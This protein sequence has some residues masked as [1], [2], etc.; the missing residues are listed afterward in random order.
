MRWRRLPSYTSIAERNFRTKR[1]PTVDERVRLYMAHWYLPP[2]I[3]T[4]KLSATIVRVNRI[5]NVTGVFGSTVV[6]K[7]VSDLDYLVSEP[8]T[9]R[10]LTITSITRPD[11]VFRFNND[12][13]FYCYQQKDWSIRFYCRDAQISMETSVLD[14][15]PLLLEFTDHSDTVVVER[16]GEA[17]VKVENPN[18]PVIKKLRKALPKAE[19]DEIINNTV[20]NSSPCQDLAAR[21]LQQ[22]Y[23][24]AI[25]WLLN[26]N[27]HF[28]YSLDI[29]RYDIPWD[30]KMDS[31]IFRGELTGLQYNPNAPDHEN[32][33]VLPR[34]RLVY[35]YSNSKLVDARITNT[36]D[37]IPDFLS[38]VNMTGP[39]LRRSDFLQH[40]GL[41]I[42]EGNDV[43]SG[44]KWSMVSN[45]VVL[46]PPPRFTSWAM[47]EL[48]EPW[49][50]FIP[51]RPDLSDVET[52]VQWM[53]SNQ[54][55]SKR[56][57]HR[58]KL[59][60]MDLYFHPDAMK[61]AKS[62]NEEIL[63]KY[64]LLFDEKVNGL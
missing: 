32:C 39:K 45:S 26:V 25:L 43:S 28:K 30:R 23:R 57:A 40:K 58:A 52:K 50:H 3:G 35:R 13:L 49:Q 9:A 44:L 55:E 4:P 33:E 31:A 60:I 17:M 47:E 27:R 2:C 34:C 10:N 41:I 5:K 61:D 7:T 29:P 8:G 16:D 22:T 63:R 21:P 6:S 54:E 38:G 48:L 64:R 37:K 1:F 18:I 11:E 12:D 36:F 15:F 53:L 20:N 14:G 24:Q 42:L 56:I 62:I 59:W 19:I 46:M 51:L